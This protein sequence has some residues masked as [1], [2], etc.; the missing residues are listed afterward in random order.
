MF[1]SSTFSFYGVTNVEAAP[2]SQK[3]FKLKQYLNALPIS[4]PT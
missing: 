2:T 3:R 4:L 1:V